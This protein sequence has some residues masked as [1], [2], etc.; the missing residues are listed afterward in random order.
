MRRRGGRLV[1]RTGDVVEQVSRVAYE[2][3]A[4]RVHIARGAT[5]YAQRRQ[6]RLRTALAEERCAL[7]IHDR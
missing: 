7:H 5:G 2:S 1:V 3:G 6:E 4:R